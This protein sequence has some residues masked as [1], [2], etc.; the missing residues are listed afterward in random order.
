M[1]RSTTDSTVT[2]KRLVARAPAGS[3]RRSDGKAVGRPRAGRIAKA[4]FDVGD[5]VLIVAR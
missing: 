3:R 4:Q 2:V 1:G 5:A